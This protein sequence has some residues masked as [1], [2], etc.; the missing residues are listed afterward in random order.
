M[1]LCLLQLLF[2]ICP[3]LHAQVFQRAF[4]DPLGQYLIARDVKINDSG[5]IFITGEY[6]N[7]RP[8][9]FLLKSDQNGHLRWA[10]RYD[11]TD[12]SFFYP[13]GWNVR[14]LADG[15][16][17]LHTKKEQKT[18]HLGQVLAR[19]D[20]SGLVKWAVLAPN[21]SDQNALELGS[22]GC[23]LG[24][25]HRPTENL[26]LAK[27][28]ANGQ[29]LWQ[30]QY[31]A[32]NF[33]LYRIFAMAPY[34]SGLLLAVGVEKKQ[35]G[36]G[37]FGP[38]HT[39]LIQ[40]DAN[41]NVVQKRFF[42][43]LFIQA[44]RVLPDQRIAFLARSE[45]VDWTG[46]GVMDAEFNW[47]WFKDLR[48]GNKAVVLK[49]ISPGQLAISTDRKSLMTTFFP[50]GGGRLWLRLN[51]DGSLLNQQ[52][53]L[54]ALFGEGMEPAGNDQFVRLSNLS[55]DRFLLAQAK[56][57]GSWPDCPGKQ[58]CKIVLYD[59]LFQGSPIETRQ[60]SVNILRP[61][62]LFDQIMPIEEADYCFDPGPLNAEFSMSDSLVCPGSKVQFLRKS[63]VSP[64]QFGNSKWLF[65]GA[66]P[67]DGSGAG[68]DIVKYNQSGVFPVYHIWELAGCTDTTLKYIQ[69]DHPPKVNLGN[70]TVL[71]QTGAYELRA[72]FS[73]ELHYA[74]NNGS[75]ESVFQAMTTG[76]YRVTVTD[77]AQCSLEDS[78]RLTFVTQASISL[79]AD[80]TVCTGAKLLLA[81]KGSNLGLSFQWSTGENSTQIEVS[82]PNAYVIKYENN[83]CVLAD[84]ILVSFSEC[85]PCKIFIPNVI[86]PNSGTENGSFQVFSDC[87][88]ES[89][90]CWLY[91]R[92]G[93]LLFRRL[94]PLDGRSFT[95]G[96]GVYVYRVRATFVNQQQG[97]ETRWLQGGI[98]IVN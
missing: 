60:K 93:N 23:Y 22:D 67:P 37:S 51:L 90:E 12:T 76:V 26:Y 21:T 53:F 2:F 42:A 15:G 71:C 27:I 13:S 34:Q 52:I 32:G 82:H 40:L 33:D 56:S 74:W 62:T 39:V 65:P 95:I 20:S 94:L 6:R 88:L 14:P 54:D 17:Y 97:I 7:G 16:A 78:I 70:D 35:A 44:I 50:G 80:T 57:D 87:L 46:M 45:N 91:D 24:G 9:P 98:Q 72:G 81:P 58:A 86:A 36:G 28:N 64:F 63:G 30:N 18:A 48:L 73:P 68:I 61:D 11:C 41:G 59:T 55:S 31:A 47:I 92:W 5:H 77:S 89:A 66:I 10:R 29:A 1:R 4:S 25:Y 19:I 38:N 69:V 96:P 83:T 49:D 3:Q 85:L 8:F 43:H 79:G 84:T 75:T